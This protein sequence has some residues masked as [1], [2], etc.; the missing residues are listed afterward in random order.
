MDI[1]GDRHANPT[2]KVIIDTKLE[3]FINNSSLILDFTPILTHQESTKLVIQIL[4]DQPSHDNVVV[5]HSTE[6][7]S[8]IWKYKFPKLFPYGCGSPNKQCPTR[9]GLEAYMPNTLQLSSR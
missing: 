1:L 5:C 9:L 7:I 6:I 4:V 2:P 8:D 3:I